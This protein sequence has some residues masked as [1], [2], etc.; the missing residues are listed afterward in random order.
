[1]L[2]EGCKHELEFAVPVEEIAGET[3]R[4]VAGLQKKVRLPGFRPGKAPA[5]LIKSKFASEVRQDVLESLIPKHLKKRFVDEG[6]DV[7]GTPS[8]KDVHFEAGEPLR[9]KAEFEVAPVVELGE[10]RGL[11]VKYEEP[12]VGDEDIEKRLGELREQKAQ[13]VNVEPRPLVDGDYALVSLHSLSG[14]DEPVSQ[15]ELSLHVG[16]PDAIAGFTEALRGMSPEEEKEFDVAYPQDYGQEKLAGKTVRFR[17]KLQMVRT[18]EL[19]E[20]NDEFARDLGDYQNLEEL[21]EAVRKSIF[22]EREYASQQAAK[23]ALIEALVASHDFAIPDAF[24]ERQTEMA[25]EQQLRGLVSRGIDPRTLQV[26]WSKAKEAQ[27][28]KSAKDVK[29]SLLL[30]KIAEREAIHATADEVDREVQRIAK[31]EREPVAATRKKLEKD[32]TLRR[33]AGHLRT[34]KTLNLLFEQARKEAS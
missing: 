15:E 23:N 28:E 24:V 10:Y 16:D 12:Q 4:I 20:L 1:M 26:D 31:Q 19:P 32:G 29:A 14:V 8:V 21:R 2:I 22:Q 30:D 7:V 11:T 33:I 17:M 6:L 25:I 5:G 18:K 34:E 13:F 27:K 3:E 9:F